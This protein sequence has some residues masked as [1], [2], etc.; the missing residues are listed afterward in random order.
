M[1]IPVL[2]KE[3]IEYLKPEPNKNYVDC[4]IGQGG[5][6]LAVL[7]KNGPKGKVLGIDW[8]KE[9]IDYLKE[10]LSKFFKK[11]LILV[12]DN[13]INLKEIRKKENFPRVAGIL[14][15]LGMSSYH[16]EKSGRGFSFLR[17]E[18]LDMR[19][20]F[21]NPLT[22]EKIVNYW[23]ESEIENILREFGEE[24]FAGNIAQEIVRE[25]KIKPIK[26]T[27][28]LVRI[29]QKAVPKKY[30]HSRIPQYHLPSAK[31]RDKHPATRT[32]QALRIAVNDEL[33]N[34]KKVLSQ[35]LEILNSD[36]RLVVISFHSLE[37]RIIKYFFKEN[38]NLLKILTK[39]P[40]EASGKEI[41]INPRCRSAKLRAAEKI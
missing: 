5:H 15:D 10:E 9:N 33:N 12:N 22:A 27:S 37:D 32:F 31:L 25:R 28:Q 11:R 41:K 13:F 40:V 19:Y 7:E 34:I 3:V 8:D 30:Q 6:T 23:S 35:A 14:L 20:S 39:K 18:P 17:N 26:T 4:T 2:Q 36:G 16:L 21:Q 29:I 24:R 38:Q 1:H